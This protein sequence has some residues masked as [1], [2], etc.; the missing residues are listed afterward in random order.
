MASAKKKCMA[1]ALLLVVAFLAVPPVSATEDTEYTICPSASDDP[2]TTLRLSDSIGQGETNRHQFNIGSEVKHLE[3]YLDWGPSPNPD[4]LALT[5]YTPSWKNLGMLHDSIDGQTND[6]IHIDIVPDS[7]YVDRGI[8]TF[9]VYGEQVSS[10]RSYTL[11]IY[12]HS[13]AR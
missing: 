13:Q 3:V 7:S 6:R 1:F 8:W 11:N 4:S 2:V 10:Q 9:D 12:Q 5:V